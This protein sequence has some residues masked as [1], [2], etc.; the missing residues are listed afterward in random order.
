M[1]FNK[2]TD[3]SMGRALARGGIPDSMRR[4]TCNKQA[5]R[6]RTQNSN[7]YIQQNSKMIPNLFTHFTI[8]VDKLK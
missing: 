2:L 4:L 6:K 1:G 3:L 5:L 7:T 8:L